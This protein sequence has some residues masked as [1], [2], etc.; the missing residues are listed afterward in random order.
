MAEKTLKVTLPALLAQELEE[1]NQEFLLEVF[2]R[3][4]RALKIERA[5]E[6][7]A[8]GDVSFGAAARMAGVSRSELARHAYARGMEPP[9]T[10]ETLKEELE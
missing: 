8:R 7:Y 5:L 10:P 4:L 1:A 3:G 6:E 9:F 2:M